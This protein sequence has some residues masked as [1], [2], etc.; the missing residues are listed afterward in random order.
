[1]T[2]E[3]KIKNGVIVQS[4]TVTIGDPATT[5]YSLPSTD[6]AASQLLQTD[7]NGNLTFATVSVTNDFGDNVF[8]ISDNVDATK[9]IAFEASSVGA[10][11]TRTITMPNANVDLGLVNSALQPGAN[12]STLTNNAGYLSAAVTGI[13]TGTGLSG[14][15]ITSTGTISL[16]NTAVT[17]GSYTLSSITVDAQGRITAASN[18]SVAGTSYEYIK[19]Q[20]TSADLLHAST[21]FPETSANIISPTVVSNAVSTNVQISL[22]FQN[23]T[24]PPMA[25]WSYGADLVAPGG[26][27][28]IKFLTNSQAPSSQVALLSG[29]GGFSSGVPVTNPMGNLNSSMTFT[30]RVGAAELG[31]IKSG[32]T[33][34]H[35]YLLFLFGA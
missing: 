28:I 2:G 33:G 6:G 1:M 5:G 14:G 16:A 13:N 24:Y 7:G 8:R 31:F 15:L 35:A 27:Y 10:G 21:P 18:G 19:L 17:P 34:G 29:F 30:F 23:R 3:F 20:Y 32:L 11:Q 22:K 9:K 12:I 4:G 25:I 26:Q